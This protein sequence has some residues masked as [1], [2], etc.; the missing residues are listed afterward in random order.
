MSK[1]K[2]FLG[3]FEGSLFFCFRDLEIIQPET[4]HLPA[5]IGSVTFVEIQYLHQPMVSRFPDKGVDE[6]RT[7][8]LSAV[9]IKIHC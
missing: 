5:N 1:I 4:L 7:E 8:I 6:V 9:V 2:I 3:P